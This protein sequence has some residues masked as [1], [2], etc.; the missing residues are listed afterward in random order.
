[1]AL[2][3]HGHLR[4]VGPPAGFRDSEDPVVRA[5]ADRRAAADAAVKLVEDE[6][7]ADR[8]THGARA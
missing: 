7:E 4:Y 3:D 1:V 5:F 8:A 2:L 6:D